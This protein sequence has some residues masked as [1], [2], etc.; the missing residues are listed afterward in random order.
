MLYLYLLADSTVFP[1]VD[2]PIVLVA[3]MKR[4]QENKILT[5]ARHL[6]HAALMSGTTACFYSTFQTFYEDRTYK[7]SVRDDQAE[8]LWPIF[9]KMAIDFECFNVSAI[10][11]M[12]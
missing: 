6:C 3:F 8:K 11:E 1:Y 7:S 2:F 12:P 9:P 5:H 4:S 10:S